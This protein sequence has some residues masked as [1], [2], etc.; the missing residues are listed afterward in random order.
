[1]G[2]SY[3]VTDPAADFESERLLLAESMAGLAEKHPDVMARTQLAG[4]LPRGTAGAE[5]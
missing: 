3:V 4:G 1:M 2:A 5:G